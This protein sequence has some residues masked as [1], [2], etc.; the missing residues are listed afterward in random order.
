M[1]TVALSSRSLFMLEAE[2]VLFETS[3][4][5]AFDA[6][7][8]E[9]A[10]EELAPGAAYGLVRKLLALNGRGTD[11]EADRVRVVLLSRNSPEAGLRVMNSVQKR[12]LGIESA[13]FT[14]GGNR[15]AYAK[16]MNVDL[17]LCASESDV[18]AAL[19]VGIAAAVVVPSPGS[20]EGD[21]ILRIALDGDSVL[22][23][24]A[25]DAVYRQH[26]LKGF[27]EHET[28]NAAV[29][30]RAGPFKRVA[31][32]LVKLRREV[33]TELGCVRIALATMRSIPTHGRVLTTLREWGLEF[34]ELIMA[35][36][37]EKGPLLE[38]FQTDFFIDDSI[39]NVESAGRHQIASAR[40]VQSGADRSLQ[41]LVAHLVKDVL[42]VD[43]VAGA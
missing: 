38:A 10:E 27:V 9:S 14:R 25:S 19:D 4:Q 43:R 15:F 16:G 23:D 42:G 5:E 12:G 22:F 2:N 31:E 3:G 8:L 33:P 13:V 36:G 35:G 18:G 21:N 11:M 6:H 20:H 7:M 39:S 30:M 28:R 1:F 17:F 40:V 29:P 26:G 34:D 24:G 41:G 37:M 32:K